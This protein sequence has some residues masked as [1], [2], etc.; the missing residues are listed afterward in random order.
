M[1]KAPSPTA[2]LLDA[3]QCYFQL[4]YDCDVLKF[5][6]VFHPSA[7][8]TGLRDDA[9]N[10]WSAAHYRDVLSKRESPKSLGADRHEEVLLVD[11]ASPNQ[12]LVKVRVLINKTIFVD[13]LTYLK[14]GDGWRVAFK[15]YHV[16]K[17]TAEGG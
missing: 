17:A 14:T 8:L 16:E 7:A 13:Y 4:M 5:D 2:E 10:E 12:A 9:I 15:A 11:F 1:L 6:D 3:V